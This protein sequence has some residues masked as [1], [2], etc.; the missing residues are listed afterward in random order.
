M[1]GRRILQHVLHLLHLSHQAKWITKHIFGLLLYRI[2]LDSVQWAI[3]VS[4]H[5]IW[6]KSAEHKKGESHIWP[7]DSL[8]QIHSNQNQLETNRKWI[9]AKMIQWFIWVTQTLISEKWQSIHLYSTELLNNRV[10][11]SYISSDSFTKSKKRIK[12]T[13]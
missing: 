2:R 13:C 11:L 6:S 12:L 9:M 10:N 4:E 8:I 1:T 7:K 3:W 5:F